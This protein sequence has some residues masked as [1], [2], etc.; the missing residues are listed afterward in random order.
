M[1]PVILKFIQEHS[2]GKLLDEAAFYHV[3]KMWYATLNDLRAINLT[4][5]LNRPT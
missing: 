1:P 4:G 5:E 3:K 2:D